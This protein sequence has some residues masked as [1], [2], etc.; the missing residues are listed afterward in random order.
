VSDRR[1]A[2]VALP[3]G[4]KVVAVRSVGGWACLGADLDSLGE[5]KI[6]YLLP[7]LEFL[8]CP[9]Q[10]SH[11]QHGLSCPSVSSVVCGNENSLAI[12]G[13]EIVDLV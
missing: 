7:R 1:H 12:H 9:A 13:S 5:R 6:S 11:T 10:Y 3:P 2:S 8:G 4:K